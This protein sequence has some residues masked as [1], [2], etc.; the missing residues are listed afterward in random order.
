MANFSGFAPLLV[1]LGAFTLNVVTQVA[2]ARLTCMALLNTIFLGFAGGYVSL[3]VFQTLLLPLPWDEQLALLTVN[4]L[5]YGS[6]GYGYF[7]FLNL[8]ETARRIRIL[9]E[10]AT[11]GGALSL[12]ALKQRYN[13]SI[14]LEVRLARLLRKKQLR[15]ENGRLFIGLPQVLWMSRCLVLLKRIYLRTPLDSMRSNLKPSVPN[16]PSK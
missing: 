8:G 11:A 12:A 2:C 6:L 13:A 10:F 9:R 16:L 14:I 7:H 15:E 1:A 5:L 4:T 3:V